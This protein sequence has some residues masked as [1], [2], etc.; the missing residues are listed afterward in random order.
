[1]HI[2]LQVILYYILPYTTVV[3]FFGGIIY[4]I[5]SWM[6][7]PKPTAALTIYPTRE[8]AKMASSM[9]AD[10]IVFPSLFSR[11]ILWVFG[12]ML[13]LALLGIVVGHVRIF[14]E[15]QFFWNLIRLDADGVDLFAYIIGGAVGIA[16][17]ISLIVL[18]VRRFYGTMKKVSVPIDFLFLILLIAIAISGDVMRF[19]MHIDMAEI[20]T[21]FASLV[22]FSP[23][24]TSTVQQSAFIVHNVLTEVLIMYIPFSKLVHIIG[25]FITNYIVKREDKNPVKGED[26][27]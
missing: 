13:H 4:K 16:F 25:S 23:D 12:V 22:R 18:L 19:F 8:G 2:V 10:Q 20:Q 14:G 5:I 15:P 11:K 7:T 21:F 3:V 1:M 6:R 26:K 27:K 9:T 17:L 24:I